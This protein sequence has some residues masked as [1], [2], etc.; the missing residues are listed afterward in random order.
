MK[1]INS[2]VEFFLELARAQSVF[3]RRFDARLG[4]LGMSDFLI[5]Y[6]LNQADGEKLRRI[7]LA[8]KVG[9]TASGITRLLAPMEKIGLV[10]RETNTTDA[11]VSFVTI[12]SGGK[13]K[14]E[15]A[16][17]DAEVLADEIISS[18]KRKDISK[19]SQLLR[20]IS[21]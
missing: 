12:A 21:R 2:S 7:D 4:G 8:E 14:F 11:R 17:E 15:E 20:E 19:Y 10:K 16:L 6:H 13:R 1:K 18:D 3:A 5:L 9:L